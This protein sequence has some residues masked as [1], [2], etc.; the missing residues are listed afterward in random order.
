M[1]VYEWPLW[2]LA[3]LGSLT[4]NGYIQRVAGEPPALTVISASMVHQNIFLRKS[5]AKNK[6]KKEIGHQTNALEN[7][8]KL[9]SR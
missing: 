3:W 2:W 1:V 4:A 9:A 7:G 6:Q 8:A 5:S